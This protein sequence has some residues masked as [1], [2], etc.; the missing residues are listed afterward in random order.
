MEQSMNLINFKKT[1]TFNFGCRLYELQNKHLKGDIQKKQRKI[2]TSFSFLVNVFFW[3]NHL[4][5]YTQMLF[6]IIH[7]SCI[8]NVL[9]SFVSVSFQ[10]LIPS[11]ISFLISI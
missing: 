4:V 3:T 11:L 1:F 8:Q 9:Y 6:L 2:Q 7:V 5:A 10:I